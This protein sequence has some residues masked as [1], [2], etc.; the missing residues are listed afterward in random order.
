M[1]HWPSSLT[2]DLDIGLPNFFHR[3]LQ[4]YLCTF[5]EAL[6]SESKDFV[7]FHLVYTHDD[8]LQFLPD[9]QLSFKAIFTSKSVLSHYLFIINCISCFVT[10]RRQWH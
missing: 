4:Q 2:S 3:H 7:R 1:W 6:I 10:K 8:G 9:L 5:L